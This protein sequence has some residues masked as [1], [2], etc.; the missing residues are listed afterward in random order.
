MPRSCRPSSDKVG[1]VGPAARPA[2]WASGAEGA[3]CVP[4][5][6]GRDTR[7][8]LKGGWGRC[9][10]CPWLRHDLKRSHGAC[11]LLTEEAAGDVGKAYECLFDFMHISKGRSS[12]TFFSFSADRQWALGSDGL[13]VRAAGHTVCLLLAL[14]TAGVL[15][16]LTS[17]LLFEEQVLHICTSVF[18]LKKTD[19]SIIVIER[20]IL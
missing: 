7:I 10:R 8:L 9:V 2:A 15:S 17:S 12:R 18:F 16:F 5:C 4:V 13:C 3:D 19:S 1:L 14:L 20:S 6:M 11:E